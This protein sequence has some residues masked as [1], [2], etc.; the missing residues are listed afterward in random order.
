MKSVLYYTHQES[1]LLDQSG[2]PN[3]PEYLY[4]TLPKL[5]EAVC[6]VR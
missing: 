6:S 2:Q 5:K 3:L 4:Y 1:S